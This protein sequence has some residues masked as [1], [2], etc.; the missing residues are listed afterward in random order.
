MGHQGSRECKGGSLGSLV[1]W[2]G[3][4][5]VTMGG[6]DKFCPGENKEGEEGVYKSNKFTGE[7]SQGW[8]CGEVPWDFL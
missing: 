7:K 6:G 1:G 4:T 8:G 2:K 3:V 5:F